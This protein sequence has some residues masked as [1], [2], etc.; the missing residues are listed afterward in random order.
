[1]S[2]KIKTYFT[3]LI[4]AAAL[5]VASTAS[6][7][8][9]SE[10]KESGFIRVGVEGTYVPFNFVNKDGELTGFDVELSRA[11]A[12]NLGLEVRFVK[13]KWVALIGGLKADKFDAIVASMSITP[14]REESVD[15]TRP[16]T[17][18][19]AVLIC[20]DDNAKYHQLSDLKG[21][22]V[23]AGMGT[24]F[25]ELAQSVE[26][27]DVSVYK[28]F[29]A[30]LRDLIAG[31]LDVIIN[32]KAVSGYVLQKHDYPVSIC[33]DILNAKNPGRIGMA[34][35]EGNTAL[36]KKMNE[37]IAAYVA[38]PDYR[39]LYEHWFGPGKPS[40]LQWKEMHNGE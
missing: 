36:L 14:E 26:G 34:I 4:M 35:K 6:A 33:S 25:A 1:M 19:G 13:T 2:I 39:K 11:I 10:I 12:E 37:A 7:R 32:A 30:Y 20:R 31:R 27:A 9:W 29:P 22:N 28:T 16:Y 23:G 24:T 5:V 18:T 8:S 38:S 21:A 17:V 40:L 15:F 3:I